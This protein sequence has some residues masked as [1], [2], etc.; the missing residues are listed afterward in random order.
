MKPSKQNNPARLEDLPNIGES[1][2]ADLRAIGILTPRQLA[3]REPLAIFI[4]LADVMGHRHDPCVLYVLMSAKHY[5]ES[6]EAL[7]WWR[8]TEQ[9]KSL[10]ASLS[11]A[12]PK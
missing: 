7:P 5:L 3:G 11:G 6:G 1:I 4:E 10:L 8:F 9:G 12:E 2:A